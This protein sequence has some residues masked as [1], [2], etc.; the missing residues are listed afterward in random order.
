LE[1]LKEVLPSITRIAVMF[2]PDV[3][4]YPY[5]AYLRSVE[6]AASSVGVESIRAAVHDIT[7]IESLI[8]ELARHTVSG[9]L[10][11]PDPFVFGQR[12]LIISLATR[13]L[14]PAIYPYRSFVVSGG[15]ASYGV[16]VPDQY[17]R[18]AIYV[19]R[20]L[21]GAHPTDLP[22]QSPTKYELIIN[23]KAAKLLALTI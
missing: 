10:V 17:R 21:R 8:G 20:I 23:L 5:D 11:L 14:V 12:E 1:L 19:D 3:S 7:G 9:L 4:R 6:T 22:V 15:L 18:S 13:H 2:N 16:D